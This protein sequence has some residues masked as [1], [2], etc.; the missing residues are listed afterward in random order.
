[1]Q[2]SQVIDAF[3]IGCV[4]TELHLGHAVFPVTGSHRERLSVLE[5]LLGLYNDRF[6]DRYTEIVPGAFTSGSPRRVRYDAH[7]PLQA[8]RKKCPPYSATYDYDELEDVRVRVNAFHFIQE[9]R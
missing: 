8:V 4:I 9:F 5:R 6:I 7:S 1:M 2:W 3:S